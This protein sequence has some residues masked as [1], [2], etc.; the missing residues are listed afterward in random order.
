MYI[1]GLQA[2]QEIREAGLVAKQPEP[3]LVQRELGS[4]L[5]DEWAD[6]GLK[7]GCANSE[8]EAHAHYVKCFTGT[9]PFE[10]GTIHHFKR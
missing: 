7:E 5:W 6:R 9:E 10:M 2:S 1:A 4:A 3:V 8:T